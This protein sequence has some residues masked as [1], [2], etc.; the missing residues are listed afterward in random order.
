VLVASFVLMIL[1][2]RDLDATPD[3]AAAQAP[4]RVNSFRTQPQPIP[5][6]ARKC[7]TLVSAIRPNLN[8]PHSIVIISLHTPRKNLGELLTSTPPGHPAR[9]DLN[10]SIISSARLTEPDTE[11]IGIPTLFFPMTRV[12]RI[13]L[14]EPPVHSLDGELF[15]RKN[16]RSLT[17]YLAQFA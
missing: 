3:L 10:S 1:H 8:D 16:R 17:E 12:E 7:A 2:Y 13:A 5:L 6:A 9:I 14:D 15:N 4:Q 11:R